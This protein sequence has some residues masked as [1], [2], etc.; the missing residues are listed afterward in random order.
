[1]IRQKGEGRREKGE[2]YWKRGI[3]DKKAEQVQGADDSI[4]QNNIVHHK[5]K[6][7]INLKSKEK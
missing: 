6:L 2:G 7:L 5:M 1:M 4:N 3:R